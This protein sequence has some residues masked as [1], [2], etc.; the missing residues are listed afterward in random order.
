MECE[1]CRGV[2]S[3]EEI[4]AHRVETE[5]LLRERP[6]DEDFARWEGSLFTLDWVLGGKTE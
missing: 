3:R 5:T 6:E 2:R 4:E 1:R